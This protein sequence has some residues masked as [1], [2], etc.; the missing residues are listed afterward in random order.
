MNVRSILA[1]GA[2]LFSVSCGSSSE[3]PQ[4]DA[5]TPTLPFTEVASPISL[6]SSPLA[7]F[8]IYS[9]DVPASQV[10]I[11]KQDLAV[12]DTW[13]GLMTATES[14]SLKGLLKL[15][16]VTPNN[17]SLW[18]KE[19]IKYI[20][21]ADLSKYQLG[22][23]FAS[24]NEVGLQELGSTDTQDEANTGGGNIGTAIY[25]TTLEEQRSR[26]NLS[27]L[28]IRINDKWVP[29]LSP[30]VG[31]MRIGPA[32][33]DPD[34]QVNHTN[35][36]ALSNSLQ[37]LEVLFHEA[38]H[39]D[40]NQKTSSVG[41]PHVIC[42]SDGTIPDNLVGIPAC[43]DSSNGAYSVGAAILKSLLHICERRCSIT[44]Q[45]VLKSIYLDRISRVTTGSATNPLKLLD[46]AP[47]TGFNAV[48]IGDFQ[49][50]NLR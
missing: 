3:S 44:E 38:R 32:L 25:L 33:F 17:L 31:L 48:N 14:Q 27:Y 21:Q 8:L 24:E 49:A 30:R 47:E 23:V 11:L 6:T 12:I 7:D 20:L 45:E 1:L 43:D 4:G 42:P 50:F 15:S 40:G 13:D 18:F 9:N 34:Y 28:I 5:T 22:L 16:A 35:I 19:R 36:H 29:V 41:F 46:P 2:L 37:R 26:S 10:A 39:S